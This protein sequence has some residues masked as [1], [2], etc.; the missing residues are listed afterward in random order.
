MNRTAPVALAV[1]LLLAGCTGGQ[2]AATADPAGV[3]GDALGGTGYTH[4]NT[5][6]V[7]VR[8]PV[9]ALGVERTVTATNW[10][11]TYGKVPENA[12]GGASEG[13][14]GASE[15]SGSVL[16]VLSSPD[17]QVAGVGANPIAQLSN[18][19]VVSFLL[20]QVAAAGLDDGASVP[21]LT[22]TGST[23][24]TLLGKD[25]KV[26][27]YTAVV[28]SEGT[29]QEMAVHVA[30]VRHAGDVVVMVGIH[31]TGVDEG[32]TLVKLMES[33]KHPYENED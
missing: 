19:E 16:L 30:T 17:V 15:S 3:P 20:D 26:V 24:A 2:I 9:S 33:V 7:T 8:R 29:S 31:P 1:L 11:A 14:A 13:S 6:D 12:T 32:P 5:T 28:E 22:Q 18:E 27:H 25:R 10:V 4:L 23:K 21:E